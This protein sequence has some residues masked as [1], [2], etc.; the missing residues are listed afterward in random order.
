MG[1]MLVGQESKD[2]PV[3]MCCLL[4]R[5]WFIVLP[6]LDVETNS[7]ETGLTAQYPVLLVLV[8]TGNPTLGLLL[9]VSL[10]TL[11]TS[12]TF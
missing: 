11:T 8:M 6:R 3:L 12:Q 2:N 10:L 7:T 1:L 9:L 5:F 4:L